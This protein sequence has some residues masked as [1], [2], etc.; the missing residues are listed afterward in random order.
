MSVRGPIEVGK[1][2]RGYGARRTRKVIAW[3]ATVA[4]VGLQGDGGT[5]YITEREFRTHYTAQMH[6]KGRA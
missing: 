6:R 1:H 5:Y 3:D 2:Y 4:I